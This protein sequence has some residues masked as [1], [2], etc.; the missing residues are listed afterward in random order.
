LL[1]SNSARYAPSCPVIP[2]IRALFFMGK[3]ST[4]KFKEF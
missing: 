4:S 2:V 3:N 1:K